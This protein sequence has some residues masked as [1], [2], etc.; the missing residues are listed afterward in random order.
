ML[1]IMDTILLWILYGYCIMDIDF[2]DF[3][4]RPPQKQTNH[5]PSTQSHTKMVRS[6]EC[7]SFTITALKKRHAY[8]FHRCYGGYYGRRY[9]CKPEI[10][11]HLIIS[12]NY[13]INNA[14]PL[15]C[16]LITVLV[17]N[18]PFIVIIFLYH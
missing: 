4:S 18:V 14:L 5:V 7:S 17:R 12:G 9:Q 2:S 6:G 3:C 10:A 15:N 16:I 8:V 13:N 1:C 11:I